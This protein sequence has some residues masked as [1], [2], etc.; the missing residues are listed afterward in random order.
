MASSLYLCSVN[1][2]DKSFEH[3]LRFNSK[4]TRRAYFLKK[5]T[6]SVEVDFKGD[7]FRS[8]ILIPASLD[9]IVQADYLFFTGDD[10]ND[11]FYFIDSK[12][13]HTSDITHLTLTLDV[14]T[15][16]QFSFELMHSFVERCHVDRWQAPGIPSREVVDEG[17]PVYDYVMKE[18]EDSGF[19]T[20]NY[21]V[22]SSTEPLGKVS[23]TSWGGGGDHG[24]GGTTTTGVITKQG[25]RFIK[26]YEAFAP[27]G[28]Y[29]SGEDFRTVGYGSTEKHNKTYYDKHKPFPCSEQLASEIYADRIVNEFGKRIYDKLVEYNILDKITMNMFDAMCSLAYNRGLGAQEYNNGFFWDANSPWHDI[30]LN[31]L[32]FDTIRNTW[33]AYAISHS[34]HVPRRKAE[35]DIYCQSTYEMRDILIYKDNGS[36]VGVISGKVTANNGDGFIPDYLP[37]LNSTTG[38]TITDGDGNAWLQP[39]SGQI[40]ASWPDYPGGGFHGG[41]DFANAEG[42][43][44][45]ASGD[46]VIYKKESYSGDKTKQ[47]YG[48][49]LVLEQQGS[50]TNNT[51]RVYYAHLNG[52]APGMAEGVKVSKGQLIGYMGTTGNST[53][54]HLHYEMRVYPYAPQ[55]D[56]TIHP[57]TNLK[58]GQTV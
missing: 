7:A 12:S 40:T 37:D 57:A 25:F 38:K 56:V 36:G 22:I 19:Q 21:F 35:A 1:E 55:V 16:Y 8:E 45:Y 3:V 27:T 32:N 33:E 42:T 39:T 20:R 44:I 2:I 15:T 18:R 31:P 43:P 50:K 9:D 52:F 34:G 5:V 28:L 10:G 41:I 26:G 13:Y 53:G 51:Y 46:G 29:L 6:S 11:Y 58:V 23:L 47:P 30:K 24:G 4:T 17:F 48:N 54:N 14:F 49:L